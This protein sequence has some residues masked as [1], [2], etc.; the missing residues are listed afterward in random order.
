MPNAKGGKGYK[1]GKNGSEQEEKMIDWNTADCQMIGRVIATLGSRRFRVFCNDNI[2]R[3]CR[4][5]GSMRKSDWVNKGAI[6][7]VNHRNLSSA[8]QNTGQ[9]EIGDIVHLFGTNLYKDLKNMPNTNPI[10]FTCV[11]DKDL[12]EVTKRIADNTLCDDDF[13][14]QEGEEDEE[15]AV[16]KNANELTNSELQ[17]SEQR[18]KA[19]E[20][21]ILIGSKR[22]AKESEREIEMDDL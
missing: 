20:R 22:S 16:E 13:F 4:L 11:E 5:C 18:E 6:V 19:K 21:A 2:I 3:V 1:K 9:K 17:A 12:A 8:T 14:L 7:L 10:L 15:T